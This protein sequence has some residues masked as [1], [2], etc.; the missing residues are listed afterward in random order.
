MNKRQNDLINYLMNE[1]R[2][3]KST[4]LATYLNVSPRTIRKDI[5]DLLKMGIKICSSNTKG[6][7]LH[8]IEKAKELLKKSNVFPEDKHDRMMFILKKLLH[9]TELQ[10]IYDLGE[11][12]FVSESTIE[13]DMQ[14]I[15]ELILNTS[16]SSVKLKRVD[17]AYILDGDLRAKR[18]L[19]SKL[20]LD[21]A[22]NS[23]LELKNFYNHFNGI[24]LEGIYKITNDNLE[25][26][27]IYLNDLSMI[28]IVIH[29]AIVIET[30]MR[31]EETISIHEID[32]DCNLDDLLCAERISKTIEEKYHI[33]IPKPEIKYIA[34]LIE[35]KR[36]NNNNKAHINLNNGIDNFMIDLTKKL[37]DSIN[38]EFSVD[39][40]MDKELFVGLCLH[41]QSLYYRNI[42]GVVIHNPILSDTQKTFPLIY[43]M[44]VF[45]GIQYEN[46]TGQR[47]NEEEM[48]LLTLHLCLAFERISKIQKRKKRIAII[49]PTGITSSR[50]L[51]MKLESIYGE[52]IAEVKLFSI[53][54]IKKILKFEADLILITTK[55]PSN[56]P[57]KTIEISP[58]IN[59]NEI[60]K[61]NDYI[62][63]KDHNTINSH[64]NYFMKELFFTNMDFKNPNDV[65]NFLAD[66]LEKQGFVPPNYNELI[67]AR[68]RISST[69]F[70]NLVSLPHPIE[71]VA[72][73]TVIAVCILKQPIKWG[74]KKVQVIF[75]FA[76]ADDGKELLDSLFRRIIDLLENQSKV[77]EIIKL[78]SFESFKKYIQ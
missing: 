12:L 21:E 74:T 59:D 19:W 75:L 69:A 7:Q 6:Y 9:S 10:S 18:K 54:D 11:E 60:K 22:K 17:N 77:Q 30:I 40:C 25:E 65:I 31:N 15:R 35:G 3:V 50:L 52:K 14:S 20:L 64:I 1:N 78:Q 56:Y 49:C 8:S 76:L 34:I 43:D 63:Q 70:G 45:M 36:I 2:W 38:D 66:Q 41:L 55:T 71:K 68:E 4:E 61:L 44:G 51:K 46:L 27:D 57:L 28:G 48:G 53:W 16:D 32:M 24:D 5:Q 13:K 73:E 39:L 37:I 29:I 62:L 23:F 67:L 58:F 26:Y 42:R 47:L 33:I 72:N